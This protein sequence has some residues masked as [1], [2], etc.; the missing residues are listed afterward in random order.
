[1]ITFLKNLSRNLL[2]HNDL[3]FGVVEIDIIY[4]LQYIRL[5]DTTHSTKGLKMNREEFQNLL[6]K[7]HDKVGES[8]PSLWE[9]ECLVEEIEILLRKDFQLP[10]NDDWSWQYERSNH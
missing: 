9:Q 3:D 5:R 6:E 2:S 7:I 1:M 8:V 4:Y 10:E